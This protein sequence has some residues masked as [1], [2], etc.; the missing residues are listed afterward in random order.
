MLFVFALDA[1]RN[2][3]V[4]DYLIAFFY[5]IM[6]PSFFAGEVLESPRKRAVDA[7]LPEASAQKKAKGL[8]VRKGRAATFYRH[9]SLLPSFSCTFPWRGDWRWLY[10][11]TTVN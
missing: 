2:S 8:K 3:R 1:F 5:N 7:V 9:S 6:E 4:S 10:F 11:F